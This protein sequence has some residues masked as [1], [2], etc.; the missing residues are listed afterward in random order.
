MK[1]PLSIFLL[2]LVVSIFQFSARGQEIPLPSQVDKLLTDLQALPD[3]PE[4]KL[5]AAWQLSLIGPAASKAIPSLVKI[6][7]SANEH[8]KARMSALNAL[9]HI[10]V[11]DKNV[12]DS[13]IRTVRDNSKLF[14]GAGGD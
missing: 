9:G 8:P 5:N 3:D 6:L 2:F 10:G 11:S 4:R 13:I 1:M 7:V 12:V 14:R